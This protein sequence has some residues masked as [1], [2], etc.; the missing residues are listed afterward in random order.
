MEILSLTYRSLR[1]GSS[2]YLSPGGG[3]GRAED[4]SGD[5]LIFRRTKGEISRN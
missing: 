5:Q 2:H 4:F 3:G 1:L